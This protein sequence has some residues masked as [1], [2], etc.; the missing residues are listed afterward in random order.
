MLKCLQVGQRFSKKYQS[1]TRK[2]ASSM[3]KY[4]ILV[5]HYLAY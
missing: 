4:Q 3:A 1:K 2:K 5:M